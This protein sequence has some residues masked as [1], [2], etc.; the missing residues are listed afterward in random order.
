MSPFRNC[1]SPAFSL[2]MNVPSFCR[3]NN[4]IRLAQS[5]RCTPVHRSPS[6]PT[7]TSLPRGVRVRRNR[8]HRVAAA[9]VDDEVKL[10]VAAREALTGVVDDVVGAE[11]ADQAS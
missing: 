2:T 5:W 7:M 1:R 9:D 4:D 8:G 11:R 3:T 10:P 6:P